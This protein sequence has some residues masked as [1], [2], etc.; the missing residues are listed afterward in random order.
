MGKK[1]LVIG[2]VAAGPKTACRVKRLLPDAEVTIVDL[3]SIISYGGC[4]I[5]YFVSG[6]V[7]DEKELR[8][9]SFHVVRDEAFF[10]DAKGVTM[11]TRTKALSID[12]QAKIVQVESLDTGEKNDIPYDKL[13][14]ATGSS[15]NR[16]QIPGADLKG[17]YFVNDM[18][19]AVAIKNDLAQGKVGKAVVIGGGAI[20]LEM[21]ESLA[22]LWGIETT[23]LEYMDQLLPRIVDPAF[24]AMLKKHLKD[25]NVS[26]FTGESANA[27]EADDTGRVCRVVTPQRTIDTDLV[28][29][30]VGVSPRS[31]LA[32]NAGLKVSAQGG[33]EVNNSM[34]T[35]D[36]D[37]YAAGDCVEILN[38]VSGMKNIAPM[39]SLANRQ[40]RVAADNI[41]GI[42]SQFEG[43]VG[44]FIMKAFE[45]C[46]GGTGLSQSS[47]LA[48]GF[49]ADVAIT[50][51]SDRAHFFPT[52]AVIMLQMVFDRTNRKVLGLQGFGPMNDSLLARINAGAGLI[53]QGATIEDFSNLELAYAPPFSTAVD[54]LNATAN[55][56]DNIAAGRLRTVSIEDFMTWMD[57]PK[58]KPGWTALDIRH[59]KEA[60]EFVN[61]FGDDLWK[62]IP[63]VNVRSRYQELPD[64]KTLIIICDAGTRSRAHQ[65]YRS[66]WTALG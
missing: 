58:A 8:S 48:L 2:G 7:S 11:L 50:A 39:G 30:S 6:D 35:S 21:A 52:Q 45:C 65:K 47:A 64:D 57:S 10:H 62:A 23:V 17:V 33:I 41:A 53:S 27:L 19:R 26:V 9:T 4:G 32:V 54:A 22:D 38:Q 51:Q 60:T 61:S 28:I 16:L 66:S 29:M 12:R 15:P 49:D 44:S 18:H 46:I 1:I 34:Q 31:E 59:P 24:A 20:G 25:N 55:A 14:L 42:P 43:W 63:Y 36:P 13:V 3:D 56:A 5:P 40:G 37:I